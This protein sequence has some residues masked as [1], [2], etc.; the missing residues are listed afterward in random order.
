VQPTGIRSDPRPRRVP[1]ERG[2]RTDIQGLRAVAVLLVLAFHLWPDTVTG[3]YVGVDVFF[4]ISGFLITAHL[5]EH[6][7]RR[8]RDLLEFWGRRIRRL[9]PAA[10]L[11]LIVTAIASRLFAPETQWA[12]IA[13]QTIASALYVQNWVLA[14]NSVDYLAA[15]EPPTPVQ[16]YWSL[17]VEEQFYLVW[18]ILLL[19]AFWL[20]WR[21]RLGPVLI[22][23]VTMLIV[24]AASVWFSITATAADPASAYFITPTRVWE[25]A[26]GGFVATHPGLGRWRLP[27]AARRA[28]SEAGLP[29]LAVDGVAW[30]GLV[31][32]LVAAFV[33]TADTPFP[34][35]AALLPVL[36][37][38]L[39]I[40][41]AAGGP[42]SPA[43][44]LRIRPIQHL[45]D[46][47]YSIYLWHWPL[48]VL[49]PDVI[50]PIGPIDAAVI[51]ALTIGL[52]TL[53]KV[54][55]EDR[56][57]FAPRMQALVPTFRFA[58]VG[59]VVLTLLGSAQLV[60]AQLR[61]N[62]AVASDGDAGDGS[63]DV[64]VGPGTSGG[65]P[66]AT[67][68]GGE[69]GVPASPG[70]SGGVAS[71]GPGPSVGITSCT[72]AAAIVRGFDACPQ[73]NA[74]KMIPAPVAAANDR[75][76]VYRDG[77][78]NYAPFGTRTTCRYGSGPIKIALVGNSHAG[79]WLPALQALARQ[80]GWTITTFL[81]SQ[82]NVTDAPLEFYSAAKSSG[83]TTWGQWVQQQV[84]GSAFDLVF[85]SERQSVTVDNSSWAN[86]HDAAVAGY[87]TYLQRLSQAGTNLLVVQDTPYPGRT[88]NS[89]PDC[90]SL[91]PT[92][93]AACGGTPDTWYWMNPLFDTATSLALP[94]VT[95]LQVRPFLCTDTVC[96]A[97][98]GSMVAYSDAS[99][100]TATYSRSI[101][102]FI[103]AQIEA[104]L[105][106]GA[107]G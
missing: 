106:K 64:S 3:G 15:A 4:V 86:T 96:P 1:I 35:S 55:V 16:H 24:I 71:P 91:H 53:S 28:G 10:F 93:Q 79:Q 33:I 89:I 77:C 67:F 83:C 73:N 30:V 85:W 78:W 100:M 84:D 101:A 5:L 102:P 38:A 8:G 69:T 52:A 7:P 82:C 44:I 88:I 14:S 62:A 72:G 13:G 32:L 87:T 68:D 103:D 98:I 59:M 45:G 70:A 18:P 56:F 107:G 50:G 57:R 17:S 75:P 61:L 104:A 40:L 54:F 46:T 12:S 92:N 81:A 42:A 58:A 27:G 60:E 2:F 47:S 11:V 74:G 19:A 6:P 80:H 22:V 43:R 26:V 41:A 39:V 21:A 49:W 65:L 25:L 31:A 76:D 23:R 90:L 34:G 66:D 105:A 94:N 36:G 29:A 99:H 95:T 48:I 63:G 51:I 9:L 20:A 97:V 37:T